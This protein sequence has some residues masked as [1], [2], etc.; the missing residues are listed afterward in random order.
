MIRKKA[1]LGCADLNFEPEYYDKAYLFTDVAV[2]GAR[3]CQA[4]R[5]RYTA[6]M[7]A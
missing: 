6:T 5:R 4:C 7:P 1:G 2:I 3:S